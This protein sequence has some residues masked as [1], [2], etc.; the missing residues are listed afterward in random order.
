MALQH[1]VAC[2]YLEA[3]P[4]EG[5]HGGFNSLLIDI[6]G[7]PSAFLSGKPLNFWQRFIYHCECSV[8]VILKLPLQCMYC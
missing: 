3:V 7:K 6:A 2:Q 1:V 8:L 4:A 5:S